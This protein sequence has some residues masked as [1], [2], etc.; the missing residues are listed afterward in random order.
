MNA[1]LDQVARVTDAVAEA[2]SLRLDF[3][4]LASVEAGPKGT[5]QLG[6]LNLTTETKFS[7]T[8]HLGEAPEPQ[9]APLPIEP[10]FAQYTST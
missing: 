1:V 8:L 3:P 6:F 9:E 5:L 10:F 7:V 4:Q 2:A